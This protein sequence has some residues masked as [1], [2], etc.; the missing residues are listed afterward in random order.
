VTARPSVK[1]RAIGYRKRRENAVRS[2]DGPHTVRISRDGGGHLRPSGQ[3]RHPTDHDAKG[4]SMRT[5]IATEDPE[6]YGI[7][8][9]DYL[10]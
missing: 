10:V 8:F 9:G 4:G 2:F 6:R 1:G 7:R 3:L 5:T